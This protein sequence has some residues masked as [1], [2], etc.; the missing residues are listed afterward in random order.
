M[1]KKRFKREREREITVFHRPSHNFCASPVKD[2]VD[3][4]STVRNEGRVLRV[5]SRKFEDSI[6][7]VFFVFQT[8]F[9][10][11]ASCTGTSCKSQNSVQVVKPP[12]TLR[13]DDFEGRGIALSQS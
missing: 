10:A 1:P 11:G 9:M 8:C 13:L 3:V 4:A 2:K 7:H 6:N 12:P 5:T